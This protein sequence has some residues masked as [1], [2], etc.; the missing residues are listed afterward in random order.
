MLRQVKIV[1]GVEEQI[2]S[3]PAEEGLFDRQDD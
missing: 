3:I 2:A 1:A